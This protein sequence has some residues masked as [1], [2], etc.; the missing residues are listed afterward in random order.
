MKISDYIKRK[1][2][3][4]ERVFFPIEYLMKELLISKET[5]GVLFK[6][7][8][9]YR[10]PYGREIRFEQFVKLLEVGIKRPELIEEAF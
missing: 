10:R 5:A 9:G 3:C 8:F 6:E 7:V 2:D 4:N 1:Y